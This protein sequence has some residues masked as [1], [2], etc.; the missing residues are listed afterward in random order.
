MAPP[1]Y[2]R[3]A[4]IT[5]LDPARFDH[6]PE[7]LFDMLADIR[8]EQQWQPDVRS[9]EKLTDGPVGQGTRFRGAYKGMGE[10]DVEITE[11]DRPSRLGFACRGSRIDMDVHFTFAPAGDGGSEIGGTIETRLKGLSR[12]MTPLFPSMMKKEMA[13]RPAQM[14]AGLDAIYGRAA[15]PPV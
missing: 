11:Y 15:T 14:Q 1:R 4:V 2:G 5:Q 6:P 3:A 7:Q 9:T 8:N 13:K 10:M 12:V